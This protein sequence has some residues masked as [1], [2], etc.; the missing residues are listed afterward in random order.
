MGSD[1]SPLDEPHM[2]LQAAHD[3]A[4]AQLCDEYSLTPRERE[5]FALLSRGRNAEHIGKQLF[6]S[7][8]TTK[9]HMSRIYRKMGVNSQQQL[10][11]MVEERKD[12][13]VAGANKAL[14]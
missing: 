14:H 9:T 5:V 6:I 10:I 11:D 1:E 2:D 12:G 7:I 4:C 3:I 13:A 8:H